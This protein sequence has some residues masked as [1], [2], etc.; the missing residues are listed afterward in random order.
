M[1]LFKLSADS[2]DAVS[3]TSYGREN[4]KE[5]SDLQHVLRDRPDAIEQGLFVIAEEYGEWEET[6]RRIDLLCLDPEGTVVVVELK[7]TGEDVLMDLQA[8]RYAALVSDMTFEDIVRAHASY[9]S[10]RGI[11]EN[12]RE[13]LLRFLEIEAEEE[14]QLGPSPRIILMAPGFS[15]ELATS[16]L[17]LN[18]QGLKIK[19]VQM[20]PYRLGEQLLI[21][22]TQVLPLPQASDY[23]IK[24]RQ[25]VEAIRVA[26]QKRERTIQILSRSGLVKPG[27]LLTLLPSAIGNS[28]IDATQ[29]TYRAR[30][31]DDVTRQKNVIWEQDGNLYSLSKLSELMRDEHGVPFAKGGINGYACWALEGSSE[32]LWE[33]ASR[34]E[35]MPEE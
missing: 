21:D 27:M 10:K 18:D 13:K 4:V 7:R 30:F 25:K 8:I 31:A 35:R 26:Q 14:V 28:S 12:A 16:V 34:V 3:P 33:V 9:L 24:I 19:C 17:W 1:G 22:I 11:E 15:K 5:R 23:Q 29:A 6:R 2:L 20:R 32:S